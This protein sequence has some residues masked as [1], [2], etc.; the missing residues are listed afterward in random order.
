MQLS[1]D[2]IADKRGERENSCLETTHNTHVKRLASFPLKCP[3]VMLGK[4]EW[5]RARCSED[6][7]N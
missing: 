4:L 7:K 5:M 3:A 1:G 6:K 2:T